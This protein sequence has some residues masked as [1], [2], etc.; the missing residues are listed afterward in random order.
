[1]KCHE[2]NGFVCG[3]AQSTSEA[4]LGS[5]LQEWPPDGK[6]SSG[7][8]MISIEKGQVLSNRDLKQKVSKKHSHIAHQAAII[9]RVRKH[10]PAA[11]KGS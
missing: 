1:M 8:L 2:V 7:F 5:N 6:R 9:V 3:M 4:Q 11:T 10:R